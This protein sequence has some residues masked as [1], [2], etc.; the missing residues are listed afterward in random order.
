MAQ[1]NAIEGTHALL[2]NDLALHAWVLGRVPQLDGPPFC[3]NLARN[4]FAEF[5]GETAID[6]LFDS[7]RGA[8]SQDIA[9]PKQQRRRIHRLGGLESGS[10]DLVEEYV[11]VGRTKSSL[12]NPVDCL[13]HS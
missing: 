1:R 6:L 11:E 4:S 10:Q 2:P 3:G 5:H 9:L 12:G 7:Y 8:Q 13:E